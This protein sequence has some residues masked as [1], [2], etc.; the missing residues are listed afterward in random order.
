VGS[1]E[2]V[3]PGDDAA[4]AGVRVNE[5]VFEAFFEDAEPRLRRAL[6]SAYG[7]ERGREAAAEALAW[8]F[9]HWDEVQQMDNPIGYLYRVGTS[10]SRPRR[11]VAFD[12]PMPVGDEPRVEPGLKAGLRALSANQRIAVVLLAGY[13]YTFDDVAQ[14]TGTS[15]S[16]VNTH[17]RR[18]IIKLRATLGVDEEHRTDAPAPEERRP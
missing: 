17:Y 8:G 12:V 10:R 2:R 14:L 5:V 9:E 16:T 4:E 6:V 15:I 13:G 1:K 18:A 3:G 7:I 11:K